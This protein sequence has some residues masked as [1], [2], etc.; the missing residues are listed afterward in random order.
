MSKHKFF[1]CRESIC[2]LSLFF[3]H[4]SSLLKGILFPPK[5]CVLASH[6]GDELLIVHLPLI[7]KHTRYRGGTVNERERKLNKQIDKHTNYY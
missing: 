6:C 5:R 2:V 1:V 7:N 3:C 4:F